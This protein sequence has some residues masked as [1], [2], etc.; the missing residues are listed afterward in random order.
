MMV[1][2]H[3]GLSL[4]LLMV[5][6]SDYRYWRVPNPLVVVIFALALLRQA[7]APVAADEVIFIAL[8]SIFLLLTGVF[9]LRQKRASLGLGDVKLAIALIWLS[10]Y[11]FLI[12]VWL[13]SLSG[14]GQS[15]LE[16]RGFSAKAQIPLASHLGIWS[17]SE[18]YWAFP[19]FLLHQCVTNACLN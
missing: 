11:S 4:A 6:Y 8:G 15:L 2:I 18:L 14:L 10:G 12:I 7:L 19:Q 9:L 17:L 5:I 13:A 1:I 3:I 16:N